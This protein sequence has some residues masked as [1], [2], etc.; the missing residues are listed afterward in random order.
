LPGNKFLIN[1]ND[2]YNGPIIVGG[3]GIFSM[4][5]GVYPIYSLRLHEN[6]NY[7]TYPTIIDII[8][9]TAGEETR[10]G[11]CDICQKR[12]EKEEKRINT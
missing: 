3:T 5:F 9:Q 4:D 12:E 7:D 10:L 6:N 8:Y 2:S 1:D 11:T